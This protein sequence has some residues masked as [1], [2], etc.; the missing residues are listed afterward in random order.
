M[1]SISSSIDA[2]KN[3]LQTIIRLVLVVVLILFAVIPLNHAQ[4]G[5]V[6]L[7]GSHFEFKL[8]P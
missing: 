5:S 6:Y 8:A 2:W 3:R 7:L 1:V 4:R